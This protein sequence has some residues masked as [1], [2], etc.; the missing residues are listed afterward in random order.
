V[1]FVI[2]ICLSIFIYTIMYHEFFLYLINFVLWAC[3]RAYDNFKGK[4][5]K[6]YELRY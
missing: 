1:D 5:I 2:A 4:Y 6:M 3:L